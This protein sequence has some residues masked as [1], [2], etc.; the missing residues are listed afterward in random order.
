MRAALTDDIA[1][2]IAASAPSDSGEVWQLEIAQGSFLN[3]VLQSNRTV[4]AMTTSPNFTL[5]PTPPPVP[6]V[7]N[8]VG[9]TVC[10][11]SAMSRRT[12][13]WGPS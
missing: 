3:W 8:T 7:T 11:I 13:I 10:A 9:E 4:P 6:V 5:A 2:V 12:G 1:G